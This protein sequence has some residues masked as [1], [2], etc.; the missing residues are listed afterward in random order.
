VN[1]LIVGEGARE[2]ALAWKLRQ[3]P[4]LTD[5]FVA[6]GNAGTAAIAHNLAVRPMDFDGIIEACEAH[7]I[8]LVIIGPEDPL[9]GGLADVLRGRGIPVY[10]P[11]AAAARIESSKAFAKEVMQRA[12]VPTAEAR[13]FSDLDEAHAYAE[14]WADRIGLPPVVKADGLAAGKG[15]TV[16]ATLDEA[17]GAIRQAIAER[18]FGEAGGTVVLEERMSG[19]ETSAH[20]F[21]D[22]ST[23]LPMP[24][25]CDY[26]R[27]FDGDQGPNTGGMGV[28]SPPGFVDDALA[29]RVFTGIVEPTVRALAELGAPFTGTLYPGLMITETGPR[30]VEFNCRFGDPETQA[31]MLRLESDLLGAMLAVVEGRLAHTEV[32]WNDQAVVGVVLAAGG[33]PGPYEQGLPVE[34]LESLD[35]DVQVFHA[36]TRLV[37]GRIV[38]VGGRLLTVA[39]AAPTLAA[40]R[41]RVYANISRIRVPGAQYRTDIA[42]RE[43]KEGAA[44]EVD[45]A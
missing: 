44:H 37:D 10:G 15:V 38:T 11:S 39:A 40:A 25:A 5:L 31:L 22:G 14:S 4:R 34:G 19:P 9:A 6:P 43:L 21:C 45:R 33:Y 8:E 2:H 16:A 23:A 3:S 13:V 20:V 30:V 12:G 26:K 32:R 27:V 1:V 29:E 35:A 17:H 18:A 42:L 24:Y 7:R 41:E 28:Y 36:G